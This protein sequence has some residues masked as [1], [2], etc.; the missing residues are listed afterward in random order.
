MRSAQGCGPRSLWRSEDPAA[1]T[2]PLAAE[3]IGPSAHPYRYS[4]Y[5]VTVLQGSHAQG[6]PI[7]PPAGRNP[8]PASLSAP[9]NEGRG[10]IPQ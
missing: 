7:L 1:R 9:M 8:V 10:H 3:P 2:S 4:P 6:N 5:E